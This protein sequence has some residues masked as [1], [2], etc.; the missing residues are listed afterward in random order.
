MLRP[1]LT[2]F[3]PAAL[4]L[5]AW[6]ARSHATISPPAKAVVDRY[7][8]AT[9]GRAALEAERSAYVRGRMETMQL[10]GSFEQW[11]RVPDRIAT[12]IQLGS[13]KLRT[14]YDGR[15]GWETDL[16][17]KRVRILEGRELDQLRSEA[18]F[19]NEMWARDD[20]GGG[21]V[22][23]GSTSFRNG[24]T[25]STLEIKPPVGPPR[26]LVFSEKT[27]LVVRQAA[28][29]DQHE[30]HLWFSEWRSLAGRKR[31]TLQD[32]LDQ[33]FAFFYDD[34][35][36]NRVVVDAVRA[37]TVADSVFAA[38]VSREDPIAWLGTP[39]V[40]R[41]PFRY[42]TRHVWIKVSLNGHEP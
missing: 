2:T 11:T 15:T 3:I 37:N 14:G 23:L 30:T 32:G 22:T 18:W 12:R 36:A 13:L 29:A 28:K 21:K 35:P 42:G 20:Q 7:V 8:E 25:F 16:A 31:A 27:G 9:G 10:K 41:L 24:E 6:P 34:V 17:S 1:R 26:R 38:P 4:L 19:E 39:G 5:C 40:A 33:E